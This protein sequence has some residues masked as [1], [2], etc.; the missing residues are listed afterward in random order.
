MLTF[1]GLNLA[2]IIAGGLGY[3]IGKLGWNVSTATQ[4]KVAQVLADRAEAA[5]K[6]KLDELRPKGW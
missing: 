3:V 4:R 1:L 2:H 6:K 5:A